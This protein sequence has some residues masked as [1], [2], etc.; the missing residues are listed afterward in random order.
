MQSRL[1]GSVLLA[2]LLSAPVTFAKDSA[3]LADARKKMETTDYDA[4]EIALGQI[5]GTEQ[6]EA[7]LL[8]A[9]VLFERGKWDEADKV[10]QNVQADRG[11]V[12]TM[13]A[14]VLR[15][16]GKL[17]DALKLLEAQRNS[18]KPGNA[19]FRESEL[20]RGELLIDLGKRGDADE[21]LRAVIAEYTEMPNTDADGLADVGKAA[22]L[23]R[24]PKDANQAL[25]ESETA[26]KDRVDT[27][28]LRAQLFLEKYDPGHAE[29]LTRE[30]LKLAPKRAD[31][32]VLMARIKLEQSLDFDAAE[33][34]VKD[35]LAVNPKAQGAEAVLTG[36]ALRDME[37][38]QA[39]KAIDRGLAF[40]PNDL[41]L[42][43]LR[44]GARFL[45]DDPAGFQ[46]AKKQVLDR[47]K[48]FAALYT[49]IAEFAEWEHRYDDIVAMMKE[50]VAIDAEDGKAWATL[51]LT[52]MRNG[53][54]KDGMTSLERAWKKDRFNVM[55]YNTLNL[56]EKTIPTAYE[57]LNVGVFQF[58]MPKRERPVLERYLPKF[59]GEAFASMKARYNFVPSLPLHLELYE[60][61]E[62]FSVRTS[63][64]PNIGIQG[65]CFG[66][67]V[68]AMSPN[69]EPFNWGNVLWHELGHVFAIQMSKNHVP[70]WFTEGLSEYETVARR[71]EWDRELDPQLY[72][73][74][75]NN[76]L[77]SAVNMNRAFTHAS[78][79]LDV[80]VAYYASSQM[81]IY[82]VEKFG[83][84]KVGAAL[85]LWGEGKRTP[86]VLRLAFGVEPS[87][88][89]QG[90]RS[91]ALARLARYNGQFMF[92]DKPLPIESTQKR[93]KDAPND[94]DAH[95][96]H[97]FSLLAEHK[98]DEAKNA[99][100]LALKLNANHPKALFLSAKIA[101]G[102]KNP[103]A[104]LGYLDAMRKGGADG[105]A[106]RDAMA[107]AYEA[108]KDKGRY[109]FSLEA[110]HR[111]DPSQTEP[112]EALFDL[113]VDEK[114]DD[115]QLEALRALAPLDQHNRRA[116]R[117]LLVRLVAKKL[118]S[119]AL[120]TCESALYADVEDAEIHTLCATTL[121]AKG[122]VKRAIFEAESALLSECKPK[123]AKEAHRLLAE[124][125]Q[126][127]NAKEAKRH[128]EEA[129]K[130]P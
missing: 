129:E 102:S 53:D 84:G 57:S 54:E 108:L 48:E 22:H 130:I 118:W 128:R 100:D 63:G 16:R 1:V 99:L 21:P 116:W 64:L 98:V 52:Q 125:L 77:P 36:I 40:N 44:A 123:E 49:I 23:L 25:S 60:N 58:R 104:A 90:F 5:R 83:I 89:D 105:Y 96:A 67:V 50:A 38:E 106:V 86:E 24:K 92:A 31:A 41:E 9:R 39:E 126:N 28:L 70:R 80:T 93:A 122:D 11:R 65:V 113:A 95:A 35:A 115:D 101:L 71:P 6:G 117:G 66:K 88:Y 32:L 34:F 3:A 4:A 109:R 75:K 97:A 29:E 51:G 111:L 59:A 33:K 62:N 103:Q 81:L 2:L 85:R 15:A 27:L 20:L 76:A 73:A 45:A 121:Q 127:S 17:A 43:S 8:L 37:L 114:R 19:T 14:R 26:R 68:A 47:N 87:A 94:P 110:A 82:T 124:L 42:L 61:R 12:A 120:S 112:L 91:W 69:S 74:L 72:A 56:Y 79:G 46:A 107:D 78:D 30:V 10:L 7:Q 119:E 13:R 18:Q 55:V